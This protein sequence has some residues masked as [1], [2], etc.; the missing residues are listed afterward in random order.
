MRHACAAC[1]RM[2]SA[3]TA[4][5]TQHKTHENDIFVLDKCRAWTGKVLGGV[6]LAPSGCA[7]RAQLNAGIHLR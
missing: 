4:K 1:E 7:F 3:W 6:P 2:P 5:K